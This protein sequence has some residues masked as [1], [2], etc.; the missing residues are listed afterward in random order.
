M[1][2]PRRW[3]SAVPL[4]ALAAALG[5][6]EI[7]PMAAQASP[8]R[9]A[10]KRAT[11]RKPPRQQRQGILPQP[12]AQPQQRNG[13]RTPSANAVTGQ[14][15]RLMQMPAEQ[16][17]QFFD[18]NRQ[19][20]RLPA[21]RQRAIRAR[22]AELDRLPAEEKELLAA[23]YQLFSRLPRDRQ[24]AARSVYENWRKMPREERNRVTAIVRRLRNAKPAQRE[25]MMASQRYR[26]GFNEDERAMIDQL[27]E[28]ST[29]SAEARE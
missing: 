21:A 18:S 13:G 24:A 7:A 25:S 16:R 5:V 1:T 10:T 14:L 17:K 2:G 6:G 22:L 29:P 28:L 23:R 19:F 27:L 9:R 12:K 4:L 26:N 20:N 15:L 3:G 11:P 8:L